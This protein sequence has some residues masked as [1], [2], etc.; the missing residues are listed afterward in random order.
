MSNPTLRSIPFPVDATT[1]AKKVEAWLLSK[2]A[3]FQLVDDLNICKNLTGLASITDE[4]V[5]IIGAANEHNIPNYEQSQEKSIIAIHFLHPTVLP[6]DQDWVMDLIPI[7]AE[8]E[9]F[10]GDQLLDP[11][12]YFHT[13]QQARVFGEFYGLVVLSRSRQNL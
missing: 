8:E 12:S 2:D 9:I 5:E 10:V 1:E 13:T 7:H 4:L 11:G 6:L 3:E